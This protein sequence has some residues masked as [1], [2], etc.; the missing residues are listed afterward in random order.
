MMNDEY[1]M[2]NEE[3]MVCEQFAGP[4][5]MMKRACIE[6][7]ARI[8]A[9]ATEPGTMP[10]LPMSFEMCL[11]CEQGRKIAMEESAG[12]LG[13]QEAGRQQQLEDRGYPA[14]EYPVTKKCSV[15]G[16]EKP[17]TEYYMTKNGYLESKCK[18]CKRVQAL[19]KKRERKGQAPESTSPPSLPAS[20]PPSL[21]ALSRQ[22]GGDHY[23]GFEIQPV[24][25]IVKNKLGF[26]EGAII[27]RICRY[28][29]PG[30][31]GRE[32]LEKIRHE[33]ELLMELAAN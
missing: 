14:K 9:H 29:R 20:S 31:K 25:F 7:Q 24:E 30:G 23:K 33:C 3:M 21:P 2:M 8:R 26:L 28:N 4:I 13:G 1:G 18:V 27:K 32:D 6:R 22:V 19:A 12:R 11:D 15:C 16:E 5:T 10:H 17:L